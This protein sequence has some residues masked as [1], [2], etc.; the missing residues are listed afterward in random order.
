MLTDN[1]AR[2][3]GVDADSALLA[4]RIRALPA[5]HETIGEIH[6]RC[7]GNVFGKGQGGPAGRV[8]FVFVMGFDQFNVIRIAKC[9]CGFSNQIEEQGHT[10]TEIACP[11]EWDFLG[12]S[13]YFSNLVLA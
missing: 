3:D 9:L 7:F 10:D 11:N 12:G 4:K 2:A 6:S 5:V 1:V 13:L 8:F